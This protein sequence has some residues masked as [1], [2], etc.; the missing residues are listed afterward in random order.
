MTVPESSGLA[1]VETEAL[2]LAQEQVRALAHELA[3]AQAT[4]QANEMARFLSQQE[5]SQHGHVPPPPITPEEQ[6]ILQHLPNTNF[7]SNDQGQFLCDCVPP[8]AVKAWPI[9][10]GWD[11]GLTRC[12]CAGWYNG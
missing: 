6:K 12:T 4:A 8:Q 2:V 11:K 9:T 10:Y 3:R 7:K 5:N 1:W